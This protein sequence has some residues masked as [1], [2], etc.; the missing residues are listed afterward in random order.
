MNSVLPNLSVI[1]ILCIIAFS[2][3]TTLSHASGHASGKVHV[4]QMLNKST[5]D[6]KQKMVFE[7]SIV[8]VNVGDVVR[9]VSTDSGHNSSSIKEMLPS[10]AK[11]WESKI[12]KD[13]EVTFEQDGTYGYMCTPHY[14]MGMVGVVLVGDHKVNYEAAKNANHRGKAKKRFKEVFAKI[15]EQ[16]ADKF[17][18]A[19]N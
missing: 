14:G 9:F 4:V 5:V 8:K 17:V 7:P 10:G 2:L 3:I 11:K 12:N 18:P 19:H 13:F 1:R 15:D 16:G 6:K